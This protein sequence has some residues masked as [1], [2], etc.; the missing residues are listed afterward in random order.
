MMSRVLFVLSLALAVLSALTPL[1]LGRPLRFLL[2]A[3][4]SAACIVIGL[5]QAYR[6]FLKG[7]FESPRLHYLDL[8]LLAGSVIILAGHMGIALGFVPGGK[9]TE[10][11]DKVGM[12]KAH[13]AFLSSRILPGQLGTA[14]ALLII[15]AQ[16]AMFWVWRAEILP[17]QIL[18]SLNV[19]LLPAL[20]FS[21]A[22]PGIRG[23]IRGT[24]YSIP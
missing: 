15:A 12:L 4:Y 11:A 21:G 14:R 24:Q 2:A 3:W 22:R 19:V 17:G 13:Y 23:G 20:A 10:L 1:P 8:L 9:D 7:G 18:T 6:I 5:Y 16:G